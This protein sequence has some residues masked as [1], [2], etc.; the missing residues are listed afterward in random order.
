MSIIDLSFTDLILVRWK[1]GV[2]IHNAVSYKLALFP[3]RD[4]DLVLWISRFKKGGWGTGRGGGDGET[5]KL[6]FN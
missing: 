6:Y 4:R 3:L 1:R 2:R 5:P